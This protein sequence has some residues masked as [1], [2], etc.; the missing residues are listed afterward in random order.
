MF[1]S[2][3]VGLKKIQAKKLI[4]KIKDMFEHSP[5]SRLQDFDQQ[6]VMSGASNI[7]SFGSEFSFQSLSDTGI[8][9]S[10]QNPN[11]KMLVRYVL[12]KDLFTVQITEANITNLSPNSDDSFDTICKLI[13]DR[14]R[15]PGSMEL[16]FYSHEGYPLNMNQYN[17][18][19]KSDYY[20]HLF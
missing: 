14:E 4:R 17:R 9:V 10:Y 8:G 16:E 2:R 7:T 5:P 19:C 13:R 3:N 11:A 15:I 20:H 1:C 12:C 18:R 6:S